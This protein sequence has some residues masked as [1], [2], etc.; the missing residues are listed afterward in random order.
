[1]DQFCNDPVY[2]K[3]GYEPNGFPFEIRNTN[4]KP[5]DFEQKWKG[6]LSPRSYS[7]QFERKWE[8]SFLST[9][10]QRNSLVGQIPR[11]TFF[12]G[13]LGLRRGLAI[14]YDNYYKAQLWINHLTTGS[15]H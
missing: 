3:S 9:G 10:R 5:I 8:Y 12:S 13:I 14:Y 1:M 6:K 7:I 2:D 11:Q 15:T 4:C